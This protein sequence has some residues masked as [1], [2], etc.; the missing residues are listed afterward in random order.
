MKKNHKGFA[1][2][3]VLFFVLL[4]LVLI[5]GAYYVGKHQSNKSGAPSSKAKSNSN[6]P[7]NTQ[8]ANSKSN[9]FVFKELG[10]AIE[11][12]QP[13]KN[14]SY[15]T[16]TINNTVVLDLTTPEFVAALNA[17]GNS[18][19][20][21]GDTSFEALDRKSGVY[22]TNP[23][24]LNGDG[25]LVKQFDGFYIEAQFPNGLGCR[26]SQPESDNFSKASSDI[27]A[28][29]NTALEAATIVR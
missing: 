14:L 7:A 11:L 2:F 27:Q 21:P 24:V 22:P 15:T 3:E 26:G 5:G 16:T 1:V 17:C 20:S 6:S 29:T 28:A 23:H 25:Q 13:I 4:A 9:K 10:I 18:G 8:P 19:S 12:S